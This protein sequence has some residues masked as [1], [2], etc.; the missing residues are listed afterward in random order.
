VVP[1]GAAATD[2]AVRAAVVAGAVIAVVRSA[3]VGAAV[4]GAAV[5]VGGSAGSTGGGKTSAPADG[6]NVKP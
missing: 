4:V 1:D 3:V 2:I 5:E 6:A